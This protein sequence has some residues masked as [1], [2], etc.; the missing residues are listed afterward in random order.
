ME[1]SLKKRL[2][3][4]SYLFFLNT[5]VI[6]VGGQG[7]SP[8]GSFKPYSS[9]SGPDPYFSYQWYLGGGGSIVTINSMSVW[10]SGN[11]GQDVRIAVVD[12]S[13][14]YLNHTDINDNKDLNKSFNF[15]APTRGTDTTVQGA[16]SHG[17]C[18]AGVIGAK[19]LNGKGIRGVSSR[20]LVS[21]RTTSGV[22]TDI[23][24]ALTYKY[25]DT[26]VSSNSYGPPDDVAELNQLYT[27]DVFSQAIKSG[28]SSG[29]G[30]LGMVYVWAGGNGRMLND[31]SNYDG[32]ASNPGVMS[33][34]SVGQNGAVSFFSEPGSN[35]WVCAPGEDLPTTD[36]QNLDCSGSVG[37]LTGDF[38]DTDYTK[39][40]TGT[41]AAAPVVSG[42]VGLVLR[43]AKL[44]SK[45]L[46]WRDVKMIL[47]ES[48]SQSTGVTWQPTRIGFNDDYGFGLIDAAA[49]VALVSTWTPVGNAAWTTQTL[50]TGFLAP[51]SGNL[52]ETTHANLTIPDFVV[53]NSLSENGSSIF[54]STISYIEY[55]QLEIKFSHANPGDLDITL[56]RTPIS[57]G[58][59]ARSIIATNHNCYD[60]NGNA[61]SCAATSSS[62][63]K[64]GVSN[65]LGESA[66]GTY[67]LKI[68]DGRANGKIGTVDGWR[69]TFYG[70]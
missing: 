62:I 67:K 36:Y 27:N 57:G 3:L 40:F 21:A 24:D 1:P 2:L 52:D 9:T 53:N 66:E 17:T 70:H 16:A 68:S 51:S 38:Q 31:R 63:Y 20:S 46:G 13:S 58:S 6:F 30:G 34:C 55:M 18:V 10:K 32:Y 15:L 4:L 44:N 25:A 43:V 11:L 56:E 12:P 49:A 33:I 41:S 65:F 14:I 60:S 8:K 64:F 48:A 45:S 35:L 39:G 69:L 59:M 42:V 7:C 5:L 47:A 23:F 61:T 26:D 29:R 28:T 54:H 37:G 22:D 19:E 50:G